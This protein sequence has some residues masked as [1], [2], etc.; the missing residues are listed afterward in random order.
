MINDG[1]RGD[2]PLNL[3]FYLQ[4]PERQVYARPAAVRPP[5]KREARVD[6]ISNWNDINIVGMDKHAGSLRDEGW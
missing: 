2:G 6:N 3:E 1:E 5:Q 4:D